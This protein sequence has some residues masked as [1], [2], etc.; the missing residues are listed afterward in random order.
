MTKSAHSKVAVYLNNRIDASAK[1]QQEI[2]EE[3]GFPKSNV[4]SMLKMGITKLPI[5]RIPAMAKAL[6][7]DP[8]E[9]FRLCMEE[10]MPD[11][12]K[13]CDEIYEREKMSAGETELLKRLRLQTKGKSFRLDTAAKELIDELGAQLK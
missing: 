2:A 13:V 10:Y 4:I 12:L 6:E 5:A 3:V 11:M 9:L 1:T 7:V 8:V